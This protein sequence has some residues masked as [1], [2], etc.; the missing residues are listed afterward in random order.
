[1]EFKPRRQLRSN[2]VK[3]ALKAYVVGPLT[4]KKQVKSKV[5]LCW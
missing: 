1:M 4:S 2:V 5:P 3:N